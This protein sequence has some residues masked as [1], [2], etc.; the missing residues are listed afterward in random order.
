MGG[1]DIGT[2]NREGVDIKIEFPLYSQIA[3]KVQ[4]IG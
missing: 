1:D 2:N 4:I 3:A